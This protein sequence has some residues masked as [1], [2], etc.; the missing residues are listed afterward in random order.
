MVHKS[1]AGVLTLTQCI[2]ARNIHTSGSIIDLDDYEGSK[3]VLLSILKYLNR[4]E[5]K[6][7]KKCLDRRCK[8]ERD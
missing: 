7:L 4:E 2:C 3:K 6:S 5:L 1:N 8:D